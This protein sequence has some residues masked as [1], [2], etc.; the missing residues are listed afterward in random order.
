MKSIQ[1]I[2]LVFITV[3]LFVR[4]ESTI[5]PEIFSETA[6]ENLF[7]S[8]QGVEAILNGAYA[9][10][11]EVGGND[12][13]Q[14][15]SVE[16]IMTDGGFTTEG[17][18]ANWATNFQDF[19]LDGVGSRLYPVFW[20]QPYQAIRNSN[21]LLENL[22]AA[23]IDD[24]SKILITA[25]A[26]FIR[27]ASYYKLY[28]R[29]G[30]TPLRTSTTQELE[31]PRASEEEILNFIETELSQAMLNL[32]NPGTEKQWGRAHK[33]AAMGVL[34]K[35][36]LNTK[37]WEKCATMAQNVISMGYYELFPEYF[38]LFQ[39]K[40]ERNRELL[41]VRTAKADLGREAN[42]SF[43][44]FAWPQSFARDPNTGLEFCDGC[45]NFATMLR[46]RDDF[47]LSFD[48]NDKRTSLILKEYIN[49]SGEL[50]NLLP[51]NDNV[52]PFKYWPADDFAGPAYGNDIPDIRYADI[53]LSRAEALNE[54]D[55][56][57][58][59]SIDLINQVRNRAGLP[60][61][62]LSDFG[63][64]DELN[65]HILKERGWEF[66]WEGKRRHDL[67]RHDKFISQAIA[68]GIPAQDH[69][70]RY[71]IPQFALDANP[72]L[73]QNEGY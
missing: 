17:A 66:W 64:K 38:E 53:L 55:G 16:E 14:Q 7:E 3:A 65:D 54:L 39:V 12:A 23:N 36:Y 34:T 13:A 4:C 15:L 41:W 52:R 40:S 42:I 25:E 24:A 18:I 8:L 73:K 71:P 44:N 11:A 57:N 56:P 59:E 35:F 43:M 46:I 37:Q 1:I 33:G 27:A 58:Q 70:V 47:W 29:F 61:L 72:L 63:S 49:T 20:N 48:S 67:I 45:R 32:P 28:M 31:I 19:V 62:V 60:N 21:I 50:I 30:P 9:N 2:I 22:E 69:M 5:E 6:P 26:R 68:R 10:F 51:P